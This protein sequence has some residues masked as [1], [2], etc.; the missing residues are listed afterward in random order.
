MDDYFP[1]M[2]L[3]EAIVYPI[4]IFATIIAVSVFAFTQ[5]Q[6][7]SQPTHCQCGK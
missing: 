7:V 5:K 3:W 2:K 4:L 6:P 1:D